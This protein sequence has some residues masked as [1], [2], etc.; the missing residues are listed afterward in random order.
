MAHKRTKAE[1]LE[2]LDRVHT[3]LQEF[4]SSLKTVEKKRKIAERQ[5]RE[6]KN[7]FTDSLDVQIIIN[8]TDKKILHV[9]KSITPL[10]GYKPSEIKGK[11][12][13]Y[14]LPPLEE[15]DRLKLLEKIQIFDAVFVDQAFRK[16]NNEIILMDLT[17]TI[18]NLPRGKV[19]L[20]TLRQNTERQ[21]FLR[22]QQNRIQQ[23]Q[24]YLNTAKKLSG[25][26]P[27]CV[28]CKKIRDEEGYWNEI[29]LYIQQ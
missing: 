19:I 7:I 27:I 20:V 11:E 17:A 26:L 2:E 3:R 4:E 8:P 23:L 1:L 18:V 29:E 13:S 28:H 15:K 12:F 6:F 10:M 22:S 25:F 21:D 9:S 24:N 14:L 5:L 16:A